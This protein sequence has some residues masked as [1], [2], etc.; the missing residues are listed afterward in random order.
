MRPATATDETRDDDAT[1]LERGRHDELLARHLAD[2][3]SHV[4]VGL[5]RRHHDQYLEEVVQR[6]LER[7]VR[8]LR[9]GKRYTVPYGVVVLKVCEWAVKDWDAEFAAARARDGGDLDGPEGAA[10]S[11]PD[12]L[13]EAEVTVVFEEALAPLAPGDREAARLAWLEGVPPVEIAR[14]LGC[15]RNAVDQRL[16]RV[17]VH[18]RE[19]L[20]P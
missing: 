10:L 1:L 4:A 3:R 11:A 17:R 2:V 16:H 9:A 8:E 12:A 13:A 15:T 6:A 20:L 14:R 7:L 19:V 5:W 18:L